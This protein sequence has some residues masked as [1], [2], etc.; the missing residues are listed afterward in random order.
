MQY[1]RYDQLSVYVIHT[2]VMQHLR[3][4]QTLL[5]HYQYNVGILYVLL[6]ATIHLDI[7]CATLNG[8]LFLPLVSLYVYFVMDAHVMCLSAGVL[9]KTA[10]V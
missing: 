2:V 5:R 10:R 9:Q 3:Y 8:L 4:D 7:V 6:E 1:F